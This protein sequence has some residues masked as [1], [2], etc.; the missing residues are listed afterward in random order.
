MAEYTQ[1]DDKA[2]LIAEIQRARIRLSQSFDGLKRDADLGAHFQESVRSHQAVWL[3][4]A[5]LAGWVLSRL[6]ARKKKVKVLVDRKGDEKIKEAAE[7]GLATG[8]VFGIL[9]F[10]FTM[11][12]PALVSFA[13][14]KITDLAARHYSGRE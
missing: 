13:T 11:F 6:P 1:G 12:K 3:G 4:G 7:T 5:G 9:K 2:E 14:K 8:L 10:V